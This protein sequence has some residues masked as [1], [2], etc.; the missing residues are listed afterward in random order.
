MQKG[1]AADLQGFTV[2]LLQWGGSSLVSILTAGLNQVIQ[3]GLP[4][5]WI[6]RRLIPIHKGGSQ[7]AVS[8]YRT[9][10]IGSIDR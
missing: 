8:N 7:K 3:C 5:D 9:I 6:T 10:M 4:E 1:K 2:E